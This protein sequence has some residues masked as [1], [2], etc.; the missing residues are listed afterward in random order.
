MYYAGI[1]AHLKSSTIYVVNEKGAKVKSSTVVTSREG[2]RAG[3]GGSARGR[4]VAGVE[5]SGIALWVAGMLKELGAKVVVVNSNRVRLI[6][7]SHEKTDGVDARLLAEL[8]RLGAAP[9]VH[10][11]SEEARRS[12][13]QLSVR[14][15]LVRQRTARVNQARGLLRSWGVGLEARGPRT[16]EGWKKVLRRKEL[17]LYVK[18]LVAVLGGLFEQLSEA[19]QGMKAKLNQEAERDERVERLQTI[20]GVGW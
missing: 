8:L 2:L 13:A 14:R 3:L 4:L 12:R 10:V 7:E 5:S 1:D 20:P 17:P 9:E 6:A 19:L 18:E 11:P 15:Q 16:L